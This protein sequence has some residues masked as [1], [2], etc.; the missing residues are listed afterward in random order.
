M[1]RN[2]DRTGTRPG[3][4]IKRTHSTA[5]IGGIDD[6]RLGVPS[7]L[8]G[9]R[10]LA[11]GTPKAGWRDR[12]AD[13]R[14]DWRADLRHADP[15]RPAVD[16]ARALPAAPNILL[17][18][19]AAPPA[20]PPLP[21]DVPTPRCRAR[22][23]DRLAEA[24]LVT[25]IRLAGAVARTAVPKHA[26][27]RGTMDSQWN[28]FCWQYRADSAVV[29]TRPGSRFGARFLRWARIRT[30]QPAQPSPWRQPP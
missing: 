26:R 20:H 3:R 5:T 13:A 8:E 4:D 6:G 10:I 29:R 22:R 28:P 23:P 24:D 16:R 25:T 2:R 17:G 19:P 11:A 9:G 12:R 21:G 30:E 27:L 7:R 1:C 14:R 18:A 15:V